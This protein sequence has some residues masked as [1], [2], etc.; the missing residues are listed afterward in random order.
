MTLEE[1]QSECV[2]WQELLRL[3]DVD[4]TVRFAEKMEFDGYG[5]T[6]MA[7][8][9]TRAMVRVQA[10]SNV[11]PDTTARTDEVL[12][13]IHELLHIQQRSIHNCDEYCKLEESNSMLYNAMEG[14]IE[15]N[16][17]ALFALKTENDTL[18][19]NAVEQT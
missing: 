4:I 2:Y 9:G 1:L 12:T 5:K 17:Q 19:R 13:L 10:N 14:I 18:K 6:S 7:P 15:R 3:K 16:A 8:D 11:S